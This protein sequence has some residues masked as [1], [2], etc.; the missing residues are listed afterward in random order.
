M[1]ESVDKIRD[2][3]ASILKQA[4]RH[5]LLRTNPME[6]LELPRIKHTKRTKPYITPEQFD[7]LIAGIAESYASMVYV[8]IY[9]GLRV[10]E[11]IGLR[12]L[13][14]HAGSLIAPLKHA[15]P[16]GTWESA[17]NAAF[18]GSTSAA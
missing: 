2:V 12:G 5:S 13:V 11:L 6:G 1:H 4:Q 17:Q 7:G 15:T 16:H 3:L 9:T 14:L 10:S 18:S 8:A